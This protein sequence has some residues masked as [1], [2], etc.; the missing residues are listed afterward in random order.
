MAQ[1]S[2]DGEER[3]LALDLA[4]KHSAPSVTLRLDSISYLKKIK[5]Q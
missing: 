2:Y 1:R 3:T 4:N 5:A